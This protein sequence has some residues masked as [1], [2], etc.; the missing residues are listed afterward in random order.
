MFQSERVDLGTHVDL[1]AT[2]YRG[3]EARLKRV[4]LMLYGIFLLLLLGEGTIGDLVKR[5]F[6]VAG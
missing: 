5:L 3:V 6:N 1:C 2:R 4:E